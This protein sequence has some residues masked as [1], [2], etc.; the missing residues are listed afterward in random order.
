MMLGRR[1]QVR[2]PGSGV[3]GAGAGQEMASVDCEAVADVGLCGRGWHS[4]WTLQYGSTALTWAAR[5]G[6]VK[7][8]ALLLDR[9][10][11]VEAKDE[12]RSL[13]VPPDV[14]TSAS[15]GVAMRPPAV[16]VV[17]SLLVGRRGPERA[18]GSGVSGAGAGRER[19][20]V[21]IEAVAHA[22]VCCGG[23]YACWAL[24]DGCTALFWAA[25][26]GKVKVMAS[27]LDC[28]ADLEARD[29]VSPS[30]APPACRPVGD[31]RGCDAASCSA[32][33]GRHAA[34]AAGRVSRACAVRAR[35]SVDCESVADVW[36]LSWLACVADD[37]EWPH[38]PSLGCMERPCGGRGVAAGPRR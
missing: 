14:A 35:A 29:N 1:G 37:A 10:A 34:R 7:A 5:S 2:A 6:H 18:L 25:R 38:S 33:R 22:G 20:S 32:E 26:N 4:R 30:A 16:P 8:M 24:Q 15:F 3:S 27:L 31:V 19:A 28:G 12:V 13:A 36:V 9:G 23:W 21:A 11:A 17:V